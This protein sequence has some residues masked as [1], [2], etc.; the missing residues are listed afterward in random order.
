MAPRT[1]QRICDRILL[2]TAEEWVIELGAGTGVLTVELLLRGATVTAVEP[3]PDMVHVLRTELGAE[4]HLSI[5]MADALDL[6]VQTM[7]LDKNR[8]P[9]V[10]GNLPYAITGSILRWACANAAFVKRYVF[11]VQKE[12]GQRIVAMAGSAHYGALSVFLQNKF[13]PH[14][15]ERVGKDAFFPRPKVDSA[16]VALETRHAPITEETSVFRSTVRAAFDARRKTLRKAL[17][18]NLLSS[19]QA[20]SVLLAADIDGQRRGETLSVEEFM[21]LSDHAARE[22]G[23]T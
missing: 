15:L 16:L 14:V 12:V 22:L 18:Q 10:A 6:D 5:L 21:R 4:A 9:I 13:E 20:R 1:V 3:D 7:S 23:S 19:D 8:R 2:T 17:S 11:L